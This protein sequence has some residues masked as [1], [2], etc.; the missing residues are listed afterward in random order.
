MAQD[1]TIEYH[2]SRKFETFPNPKCLE[3]PLANRPSR[4]ENADPRTKWQPSG[5]TADWPEQIRPVCNIAWQLT[6]TTAT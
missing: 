2:Y 4:A 5:Y 3:K 6:P 1:G